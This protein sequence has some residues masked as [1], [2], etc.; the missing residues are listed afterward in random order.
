MTEEN[1][2]EAECDI[3]VPAANEK[4]ITIK[5]AHK[6]QAKVGRLNFGLT[7]AWVNIPWNIN[8]TGSPCSKDKRRHFCFVDTEIIYKICIRKTGNDRF[9]NLPELCV[10]SFLCTQPFCGYFM[11]LILTSMKSLQRE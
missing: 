4:Q 5:N 3:L 7:L 10:S 1:L 2:L 11:G 6:I 8:T 9:W